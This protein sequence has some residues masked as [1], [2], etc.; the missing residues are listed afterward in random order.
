MR[1]SHAI[2][3]LSF[4]ILSSGAQASGLLPYEDAERIANGSVVYNEYCAVCHGADL[5]GQVEEWRQPDADGFLPA[6]PHDETGH[7]W[8]HAD[9]L[10]INIVT[11]GT[12]AIVGGT[13]KSNMMGFGD[14]LSREEIEDVLAFIKST[15][16]DEVI[17]IHNGINERA[18]LYGN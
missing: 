10:L 3:I 7:T 15:W 11:R 2:A 8:H 12:E 4:V 13:Y 9:D 6:P 16:S 14:V 5:E 17:E 1:P 18:S